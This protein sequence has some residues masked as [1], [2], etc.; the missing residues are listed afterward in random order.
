MA[1]TGTTMAFR[2]I[3][4]LQRLPDR[5]GNRFGRRPA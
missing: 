1:S 4:I 5:D 3:L 2:R